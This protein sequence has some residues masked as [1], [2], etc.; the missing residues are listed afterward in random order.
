[1]TA[2]AALKI[3]AARVLAIRQAPYLA[4]VL[5]RMVLVDSDQVPTLGV[6]RRWRIYVNPGFAAERTVEDLA[7]I[8]LHEAGHC[9]RAHP[10]RWAALGQPDTLHG[11][12]NI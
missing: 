9:L 7:Y 4:S 6:D 1:M 12:F 11:I 3:R 10:A 5:L 2:D 8:W